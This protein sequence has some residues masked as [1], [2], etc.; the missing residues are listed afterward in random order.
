[1]DRVT[2][3]G[4][5][6]WKDSKR[7]DELSCLADTSAVTYTYRNTCENPEG[8]PAPNS[9]VQFALEFGEDNSYTVT[10]VAPWTGEIH[11]QDADAL[12]KAARDYHRSVRERQKVRRESAK[13]RGDSVGTMR[14]VI[15]YKS[16]WDE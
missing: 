1:M 3:F 10:F 11:A 14:D 2:F 9:L 5:V 4:V 13:T 12:D 8:M 15:K 16:R 6:L 7:G